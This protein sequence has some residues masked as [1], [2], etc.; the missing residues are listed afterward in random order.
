MLNI[1]DIMETVTMNGE[2]IPLEDVQGLYVSDDGVIYA[3][4]SA[5]ARILLIKDDQVIGTI[6]RPVSNLIADD[7]K[8]APTKVGIDI[9]GRAFLTI[10]ITSDSKGV[11]ILI[12]ADELPL[13]DSEMR[14]LIRLARNAGFTIL[15]ENNTIRLT[16]E[17][18]PIAIHRVYTVSIMDGKRIMLGKMVEI[19]CHGEPLDPDQTTSH[20]VSDPIKRHR[21]SKNK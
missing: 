13:C 6:D 14:D 10:R 2:E 5:L 1:K 4:Q 18:S 8:F 16:V 21:R 7:F 17:F 12:E 20:P 19:F 11:S 9:Y 3:C 15:P